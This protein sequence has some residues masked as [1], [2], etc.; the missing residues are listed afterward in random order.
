MNSRPLRPGAANARPAATRRR[1]L[2]LGL[3]PWFMGREAAAQENDA[4]ALDA[5]YPSL[6]ERPV[7]AYGYRLLDLALRRAERPY[8]LSVA[9]TRVTGRRADVQMETGEANVLD[10]GLAQDHEL[11]FDP[12]AFPLDLGLSGCR[13]FLVRRESLPALESVRS[14]EDLR[15][16]RFGQGAG[17]TDVWLL[18]KAGLRVETAPFA[19]LFRMLEA[20]RF[21]ILALGA[22][23]AHLLL[24]RFQAEAPSVVVAPSLA[25]HYPFA[26]MFIVNRNARPLHGALTLGLQRAFDDGSLHKLLAEQPGLGPL[27]LGQRRLPARIVSLAHPWPTR[28]YRSIPPPWLHPAV[29][30]LL[31][32]APQDQ[33]R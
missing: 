12:V 26:R 17:W 6:P 19:A 5:R 14:L 10:V 11:R 21:D 33:R 3:L 23:E 25:L 29:R 22:D 31:P 32:A 13:L 24:A 18:R 8:R 7:D 28:A 20:R 4:G 2:P 27:V 16:L 30:A 15:A 1:L 9:T